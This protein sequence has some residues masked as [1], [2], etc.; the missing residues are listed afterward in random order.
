M[1]HC[2]CAIYIQLRYVN[3]NIITFALVVNLESLWLQSLYSRPTKCTHPTYCT[4]CD[5][6][7]CGV[8]MRLSKAIFVT[9]ILKNSSVIITFHSLKTKTIVLNL[10]T[11]T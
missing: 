6:I 3:R 4:N 5:F 9:E 10:G 1:V 11:T 2:V 8:E 7:P